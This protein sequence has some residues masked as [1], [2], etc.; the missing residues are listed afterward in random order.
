MLE[1]LIQKNRCSFFEK[2][3][4][5]EEAIK[6]ACK[7]LE[8]QKVIEKSYAHEIIKSVK[9]YGPYII[10]APHIAIPHAQEGNGVNET[11]IAFMK[12]EEPV[13]FSQSEEESAQ[14]FFV[15]ASA[16]NNIHLKNLAELVEILSDEEFV[17]KLLKVKNIE[18][19]KSLI[20]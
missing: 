10:I 13:Q 19:L 11:A 16:D 18:Q 3:E 4:N 6:A 2:F 9:K 1:E 5:W 20:K 12:T 14:L 8:E 15:L 7:P 17:S